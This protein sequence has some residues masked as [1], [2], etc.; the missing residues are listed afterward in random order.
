MLFMD[1]VRREALKQAV[2]ASHS[3]IWSHVLKE[4]DNNMEKKNPPAYNANDKERLW[5]RTVGA[6]IAQLSFVA[7]ITGER[8]YY[9]AAQRWA[10]A[11]CDYPTW[12]TDDTPDGAEYGL[13]CGHQLFGLAMAYDYGQHNLDTAALA[14]IRETLIAKTGRAYRAFSEAAYPYLQNQTWIVATGILAAALVLQNECEDAQLWIDF[15]SEIF[16]TTSFMLSPDGVSQEGLGYWQYRMEWLMLGFDL[17]KNVLGVNCYRNSVYWK[18]TATYATCM[19]TPRNS[20]TPDNELINFS[21]CQRYSKGSEPYLHRLAD[22]NRD[23]LA[24]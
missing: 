23:P 4:T 19:M 18:N 13:A 16:K 5:Q 2:H 24:Q 3:A 9:A 1:S 15:V 6:N 10:M 22:L 17:M 12:G 11:C 20:R 21:D 14:K 8:K 7:S